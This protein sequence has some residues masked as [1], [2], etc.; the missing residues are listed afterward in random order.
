MCSGSAVLAACRWYWDPFS[1]KTSLLTSPEAGMAPLPP[2]G[3]NPSPSLPEGGA[4]LKM[5]LFRGEGAKWLRPAQGTRNYLLCDLVHWPDPPSVSPPPPFNLLA[6]EICS[7]RSRFI[8]PSGFLVASM[9]SSIFPWNLGLCMSQCIVG[10]STPVPAR[11]IANA[12]A[13]PANPSHGKLLVEFNNVS[14]F[15]N[16][17]T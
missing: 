15:M 4:A 3:A 12:I 6:F 1:R 2:R 14:W 8:L 7:V 5:P 16:H 17:P 13:L 10:W 11:A 9:N